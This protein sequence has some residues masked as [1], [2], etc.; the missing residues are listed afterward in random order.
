MLKKAIDEHRN[1][2]AN[3]IM[4]L[5][6]LNGIY[7]PGSFVLTKVVENVKA[8]ID[9]IS[10]SAIV[11]ANKNVMI[12]NPA[13]YNMI[14]NRGKAARKGHKAKER[15][16]ETEKPWDKVG[17]ILSKQVKI[18]VLFLAGLLDIVKELHKQMGEIELPN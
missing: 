13:T 4:H 8:I 3:N 5:Y 17:E 7:Y 12:Y 1:S 2:E 18:K 14:P 11:S 9:T 6:R 15:S 10:Q 16:I